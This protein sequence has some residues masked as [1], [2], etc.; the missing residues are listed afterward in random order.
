DD[1]GSASLLESI[2][3]IEHGLTERWDAGLHFAA[4]QLV[5]HDPL[6]RSQP[7]AFRELALETR[8]RFA[9]RSEL[10]VDILAFAEVAKQ[11]GTAVFDVESRGIF[12]RDTGAF[13][14][15]VNAIAAIRFGPDA[16]E[17]EVTL[18]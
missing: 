3:E 18:G 9:D 1:A 14:T 10:P 13:T 6:L 2:L 5:S 4:T 17:T 8:Y 7:F 12:A 11:F 15:A 16:P